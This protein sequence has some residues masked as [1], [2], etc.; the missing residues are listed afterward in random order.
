MRK[1]AFRFPSTPTPDRSSAKRLNEFDAGRMIDRPT[2]N[3][4]PTGLKRKPI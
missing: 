4:Y 3:G 2:H 1:Q